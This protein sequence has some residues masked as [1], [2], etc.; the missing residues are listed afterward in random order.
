VQAS[1]TQLEHG[2]PGMAAMSVDAPATLLSIAARLR[3]GA[4]CRAGHPRVRIEP[5]SVRK[6]GAGAMCHERP[7]RQVV[8]SL[9]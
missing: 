5:S 3:P 2:R 8:P 4:P 9:G 7:R 1:R 6:V